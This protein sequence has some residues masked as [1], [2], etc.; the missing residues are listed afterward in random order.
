MFKAAVIFKKVIMH[1]FKRKS[2]QRH[3]RYNETLNITLELKKTMTTGHQV[4]HVY[5][6]GTLGGW[7]KRI[8]G[9]GPACTIYWPSSKT[10][11]FFVL[12][13]FKG[14]GDTTQYRGPGFGFQY[15]KNKNSDRYGKTV[16]RVIHPRVQWTGGWIW[17][18]QTKAIEFDM[19]RKPR[20]Q[21]GK[22][23]NRAQGICGAKRI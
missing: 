17:K 21:T 7:G 1:S 8:I 5:D 20:K 15:H 16:G 11:V 19:S 14:S 12:F 3:G 22:I 18:L 2:Q 9:S 10:L 6:P 13:F 4:T 23:M